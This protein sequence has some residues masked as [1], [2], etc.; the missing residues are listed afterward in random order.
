MVQVFVFCERNAKGAVVDI[1]SKATVGDLKA[2][3]QQ[4]QS[5]MAR[6]DTMRFLW[7]RR[8]CCL[9]TRVRWFRWGLQR[10]RQQLFA[11]GW[12]SDSGE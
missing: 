2:A 7:W 6:C 4:R 9:L 10:I 8:L 11:D 3:I 12:P 5:D 1:K